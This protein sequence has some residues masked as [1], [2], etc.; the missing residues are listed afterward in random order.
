M[1]DPLE[2]LPQGWSAEVDQ[3]AHA[4]MHQPQ[5]GK[6]LPGMN[7]KQLFDGFDLYD[8]A[9]LRQAD[10]R[11]NS[12]G[13]EARHNRMRPIAGVRR[14]DRAAQARARVRLRKW[15]PAIPAQDPC[16]TCR[17][18]RQSRQLCRPELFP[19]SPPRP[20]AYAKASADERN[21]LTRRS[22][23]EGGPRLRV[24]ILFG[25]ITPCLP[26]VSQRCHVRDVAT[27]ASTCF[28]RTAVRA[29]GNPVARV[30]AQSDSFRPRTRA[31][32]VPG[33]SLPPGSGMTAISKRAHKSRN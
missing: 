21:L 14:E 2:S 25:S 32:R 13:R 33:A 7:R 10:R 18:R 12:R 1:D 9:R 20:S 11:A 22:F 8:N 27:Y 24:P 16:V 5:I 31:H 6:Q 3:Q 19:N 30:G 26:T 29:S 28:P 23:S 17:Q 4:E 15:I